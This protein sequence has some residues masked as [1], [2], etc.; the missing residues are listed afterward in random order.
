MTWPPPNR[1]AKVAKEPQ[2]S[3]SHQEGSMPGAE[4][5]GSPPCRG[6]L[7]M[8]VGVLD[9]GV[10]CGDLTLWLPDYHLP[11]P[12][13]DSPLGLQDSYTETVLRAA[14]SP[15]QHGFQTPHGPAQGTMWGQGKCDHPPS[16]M[17]NGGP[18]WQ[19]GRVAGFARI[20]GPSGRANG[21]T[22]PLLVFLSLPMK[23]PVF[24]ASLKLSGLVPIPH[25]MAL[26]LGS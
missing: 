25:S 1:K 3:L 12:A 20:H 18:V 9:K 7:R 22:R 16:A 24:P 4:A 8:A 15:L 17:K 11:L 6:L 5:R 19:T 13:S 21:G 26:G 23:I 10:W 2:L 14:Y